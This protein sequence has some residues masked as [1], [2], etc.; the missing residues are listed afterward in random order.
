M[1]QNKRSPHPGST[2]LARPR[3]THYTARHVRVPTRIHSQPCCYEPRPGVPT[4]T[5]TKTLC[6]HI[7]VIVGV[8]KNDDKDAVRAYHGH[9]GCRRRR[10]QRRCACVSWSSS[11]PYLL[12]VSASGN[13][14]WTPSHSL[15]MHSWRHSCRVGLLTP[16]HTAAGQTTKPNESR[17]RSIE[18]TSDCL[19]HARCTGVV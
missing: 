16:T 11:G 6:V 1:Q 5:T 8:N 19:M 7:M 14:Y 17:E 10:L 2:W 4:T 15:A 9:R 18:G 13:Q 12:A 3:M